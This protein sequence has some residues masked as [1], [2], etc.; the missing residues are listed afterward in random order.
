ASAGMTFVRPF[1]ASSAVPRETNTPFQTMRIAIAALLLGTSLRA[2][3]RDTIPLP[4][5]PRPDFERAEW[6][7]LNGRW[8]FAFDP[9][10]DGER[11]GWPRGGMPAAHRILVPFSWGAP[12]S[13]VPDS[14]DVAWYAR[15]VTVP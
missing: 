1:S 4:E 3:P 14:A 12:A 10:D 8:Q 2:Q 13:G 5:H 11:L 15:D 6:L 9:R 7:N